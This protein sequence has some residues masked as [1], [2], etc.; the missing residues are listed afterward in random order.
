MQ[1]VRVKYE[2]EKSQREMDLV[3]Q[4][5]ETQQRLKNIVIIACLSVLLLAIAV[6]TMA[7]RIVISTK[8]SLLVI[9]G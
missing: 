3:R 4:N 7:N 5:Y 8:K 9:S 1:N 6:E 2:R